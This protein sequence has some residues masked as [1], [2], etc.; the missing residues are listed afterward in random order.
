MTSAPTSPTSP[1]LQTY[2]H[3][4]RRQRVL[5]VAV[6]LLTCLLSTLPAL[7]ADARYGSSIRIR[8]SPLDEQGVFADETSAS[9]PSD[10]AREF[11]TE[12]EILRST[13]L[14]DVVTA[15]LRPTKVRFDD[16]IITQINYSEV[17]EVT[18]H[19]DS[20]K[21][22]AKVANAYGDVYVADRRKRTVD[23]LV[24]KS[25]ELRAQSAKAQTEYEA[26]GR[27]LAD[28]NT[29]PSSASE[30]RLRQAVLGA[31]IQDYTKRADELEV[32][33][34]LRGNATQVISP[35][36]IEGRRIN[37]NAPTNAL[38]G[39]I[40]GLLLA[41]TLAV[42][43]DTAQDRLTSREDLAGVRPDAPMLATVP[44]APADAPVGGG[45]FAVQEAYRYLRTG[46]RLFSLSAPAR[47][48]LVTSATGAEGKTTTA[49]N[50]AMAM[51]EAGDRVVLVDCDLR[52]PALHTRFNLVNKVGLTSMVMGDASLDDAISFVQDNLAVV[53]SGPPVQN[54][55]EML[56]SDQFAAVLAAVIDQADITILDSP[57]VLPVADALIIGQLVDGALVVSRIGNV[58][59]RAVRD[60][61]NRLDEARVPLVGLVANDSNESAPAAYG[62]MGLEERRRAVRE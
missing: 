13:P 61:L 32:E 43:V 26:V 25:A 14:R 37:Q 5:I 56:G 34:S 1:S 38:L 7:L 18:I 22:A 62:P 27:D 19:A 58:R 57:P 48:L 33:G 47:S 8:I 59:R 50:L 12:V 28:P 52:R 16:P 60:V 46:V 45:G 20:P 9:L 42:L 23:A 55:T 53:T 3:V 51:A 29:S 21:V 31:Q 4:L 39:F 6:T 10:R 17:A 44:H 54:P 11:A 40:L 49:A 15:Q 30:L 2:L 35:A 41:L 36:E 24:A